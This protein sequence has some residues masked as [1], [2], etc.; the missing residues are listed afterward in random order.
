M[1]SGR[2]WAFLNILK[3][4]IEDESVHNDSSD[5]EVPDE[6]TPSWWADYEPE[7]GNTEG[8]KDNITEEGA[9]FK[10]WIVYCKHRSTVRAIERFL[11]DACDTPEDYPQFNNLLTLMYEKVFIA[12]EAPDTHTLLI[13]KD[14]LKKRLKVIKEETGRWVRD[15][16]SPEIK[17]GILIVSD[18]IPRLDDDDIFSESGVPLIDFGIRFDAPINDYF[19]FPVGTQVWSLVSDSNLEAWLRVERVRDQMHHYL[20]GDNRE[21]LISDQDLKLNTNIDHNSQDKALIKFNDEYQASMSLLERFKQ[22]TVSLVAKLVK[23]CC[24]ADPFLSSSLTAEYATDINLKHIAHVSL[25]MDFPLTDIYHSEPH[26]SKTNSPSD[27]DMAKKKALAQ[28]CA[29][30]IIDFYKQFTARFVNIFPEND[31]VVGDTPSIDI[32]QNNFCESKDDQAKDDQ[33]DKI[34]QEYYKRKFPDCLQGGPITPGKPLYLYHIRFIR[35]DDYFEKNGSKK[36]FSDNP[37]DDWTIGKDYGILSHR[38]LV[39]CAPTTIFD[40]CAKNK[41]AARSRKVTN[42]VVGVIQVEILLIRSMIILDHQEAEQ[43]T[44]FHRVI[45]LLHNGRGNHNGYFYDYIKNLYRDDTNKISKNNDWHKRTHP[46]KYGEVQYVFAPLILNKLPWPGFDIDWSVLC[47]LE[48][49]E[50]R[51]LKIQ[52]ARCQFQARAKS[53]AK[54]IRWDIKNDSTLAKEEKDAKLSEVAESLKVKQDAAKHYTD[55]HPLLRTNQSIRNH[56]KSVRISL[57]LVIE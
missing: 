46:N 3:S 37:N 35:Q 52:Q 36:V 9:K 41:D 12:L 21:L 43:L 24:V 33:A 20:I 55:E 31:N 23:E 4:E 5:A 57:P 29:M 45:T 34:C 13:G 56:M 16:M 30:V 50:L 1:I 8:W 48:N 27:I 2:L 42:E 7:M 17:S 38:P 15:F 11:A 49:F 51:M 54:Q 10:K 26:A 47:E 32:E 18:A 6:K 25:P 19:N 44:H 53:E 40:R 22:S 28:A 14:Q 39:T